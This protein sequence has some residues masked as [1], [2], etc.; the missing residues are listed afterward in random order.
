MA[1]KIKIVCS[2]AAYERLLEA[3][4]SYYEDGVCVLGKNYY[5]CPAMKNRD[6]TCKECLR[7]NIVRVEEVS[8]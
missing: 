8:E 5:T 6:L 1:R 2:K 3:V 4:K 7:K